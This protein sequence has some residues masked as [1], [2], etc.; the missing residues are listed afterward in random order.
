MASNLRSFGL[1]L[2]Q[3]GPPFLN[4]LFTAFEQSGRGARP[5]HTGDLE[6]MCVPIGCVEGKDGR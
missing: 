5:E 4:S 2:S 6:D 3:A 1:S